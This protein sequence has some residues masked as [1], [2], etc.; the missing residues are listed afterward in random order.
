M[1]GLRTEM[2]ELRSELRSE[3]A[4]IRVEMGDVRVETANLSASVDCRLREQTWMMM[5]TM[6]AAVGFSATLSRF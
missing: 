2:S 1:A 4:G 3:M 6:I 5:T